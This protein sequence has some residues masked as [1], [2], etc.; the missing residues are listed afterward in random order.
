MSMKQTNRL[1]RAG[2]VFCA[3]ALVLSLFPATLAAGSG[4]AESSNINRQNYSRWSSPVT[5]YLYENES[6]GLT[7]V[8]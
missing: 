3:G 5:S 4:S 6:G 2:A 7:R 1:K 8:E